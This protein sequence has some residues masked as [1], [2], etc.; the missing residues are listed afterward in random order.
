LHTTEHD[1]TIW[2]NYGKGVYLLTITYPFT[3]SLG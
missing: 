3:L 1:L 2:Q